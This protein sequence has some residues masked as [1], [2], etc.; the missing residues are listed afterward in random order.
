MSAAD[1]RLWAVRGAAQADRNDEESILGATEEL[2]RELMSRNGLEPDDFVSVILTC[3]DDLNA[4]FPAVGARAV[5]LDQVPLLCNRE[6]DVPGAMERVI[7]V[8][9]HYYAPARGT[10]PSTSISARRRSCAPTYTRRNDGCLLREAGPDPGLRRRRAGGQGAG[11]DRRRGDR[12]ARLERV[13]LGPAPEG[14]RGDRARRRR[15]PSL[16]GSV[17]VP[18]APPDRRPLRGGALR[19]RALQRLLRDPARG[20][21]RPLRARSRAGLR[22]ALVLDIPVFGAAVGGARDPRAARRGRRPRPRRDG[23]RGHGS[24][25]ARPD[26][27][28]EQPDRDPRPGCRG[29]PTSAPACPTT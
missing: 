19:G 2:M 1:Q 12:P 9:A 15:G 5:G 18:A 26:L 16:P 14:D 22:L 24:D 8:L 21:A 7:R 10:G 4:Q 3:T 6:L 20:V 17:G 23:H 11:V 13:T 25:A 29:S 28:P 27:Q